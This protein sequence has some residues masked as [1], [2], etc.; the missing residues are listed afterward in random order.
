MTTYKCGHTE[1]NPSPRCS[2]CNARL[3]MRAVKAKYKPLAFAAIGGKCTR[4]GFTDERALQ[5][6]HVNGGGSKIRKTRGTLAQK[7][8]YKRIALGEYTG[9]ALQ[10]LCANCNIIKRMENKEYRPTRLEGTER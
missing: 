1:D 7:T 6:D 8:L 2:L 3:A 10:L 4:C 5:L 9:P